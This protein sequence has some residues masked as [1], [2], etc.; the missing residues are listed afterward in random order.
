MRRKN[1]IKDLKREKERGSEAWKSFLIYDA[2]LC[3]WTLEK[4]PETY[5]AS[6]HTNCES[7]RAKSIDPQYSIHNAF[8]RISYC[9]LFSKRLDKGLNQI[10]NMR[11]SGEFFELM[12]LG[13]LH[14]HLQTHSHSQ[15]T[16]LDGL[17]DSY[18]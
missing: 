5:E 3:L 16:E 11:H 7:C 1:K 8:L 13:Y 17:Y 4:E 2:F 14:V 18:L 10:Q 12:R 6:F 15:C 9:S